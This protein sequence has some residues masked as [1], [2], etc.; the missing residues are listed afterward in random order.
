M[1]YEY[2]MELIKALE[3][4]WRSKVLK[5][6]PDM[7]RGSM[8]TVDMLAYPEGDDEG[9]D[10][11]GEDSAIMAKANILIAAMNGVL[12]GPLESDGG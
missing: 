9:S 6:D 8:R 4:L 5:Q 12:E 1:V 7:F 3:N 2:E 10:D 11:E